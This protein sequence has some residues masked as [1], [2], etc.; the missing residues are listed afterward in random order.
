[1]SWVHLF[2]LDL[3]FVNALM[4]QTY[5]QHTHNATWNPSCV[6][7]ET[8]HLMK[9]E[10][11][12]FLFSFLFCCCCSFSKWNEM[13]SHKNTIQIYEQYISLMSLYI[14]ICARNVPQPVHCTPLCTGYSIFCLRIFSGLHKTTQDNK[15]IR[16]KL[17][18]CEKTLQMWPDLY[19]MFYSG[20]F[21]LT[22]WLAPVERSLCMCMWIKS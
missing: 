10:T 19:T 6:E 15:Y 3:I 14:K 4:Q 20:R 7:T 11:L 22:G 5:S 2:C 1:M 9:N 16:M 21:S 17:K 18:H 12:P 8:T 13:H